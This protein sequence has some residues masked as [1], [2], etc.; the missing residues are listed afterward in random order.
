PPPPAGTAGNLS[1]SPPV[2]SP[3]GTQVAFASAASNLVP[4]VVDDNGGYDVFVRD[5]GTGTTSLESAGPDGQALGADS[6]VGFTPD[7]RALLLVSIRDLAGTGD[8]ALGDNAFLRDLTD[9][10]IT[11]ATPRPDANGKF[12]RLDD[13]VLSPDG[14]KAVFVPLGSGFGPTDTNQSFDVYLRDLTAGTTTLVSADAARG[15][16][17]DGP[18]FYP[19]FSPD[20]TK[21]AFASYA[22]DLGP[23]DTHWT[24]DVYLRDLRTA[25]A[26]LVSVNAAGT[27]RG[28]ARSGD[29][30]RVS[31]DPTGTRIAFASDAGDLGPTDTNYITDVYVRDLRFGIT[32]LVSANVAGTD[33]GD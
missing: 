17:A 30:G 18:S 29:E 25:S 19:V 16:A 4:G 31:F 6:V 5:L 33:A 7:S 14:T 26:S 24:M 11:V 1:P 15:D 9:G 23:T 2:V 12:G 3:D 21:V 20:S 32:T 10:G 8:D 28:S 13:V 22:D 27:D